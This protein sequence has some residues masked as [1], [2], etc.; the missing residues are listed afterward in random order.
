[1]SSSCLC[2]CLSNL[3]S[4]LHFHVLFYY[5]F[6]SLFCLSCSFLSSLFVFR[7]DFVLSTFTHIRQCTL[8]RTWNAA[9]QQTGSFRTSVMIPQFLI[10]RCTRI[11]LYQDSIQ[12]SK[13]MQVLVKH[14]YVSFLHYNVLHFARLSNARLAKWKSLVMICRVQQKPQQR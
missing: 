2:P 5:Y 1:V 11:A 3:S 10:L 12:C 9:P 8:I 14:V 6:L 7:F 4:V 13:R